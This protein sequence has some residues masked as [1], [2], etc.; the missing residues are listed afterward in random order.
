MKKRLYYLLLFLLLFFNLL[1]SQSQEETILKINAEQQLSRRIEETLKPFIGKSIAV[2]NLEL[3]YANILEKLDLGLGEKPKFKEGE[4]SRTRAALLSKKYDEEER[5]NT[6]VKKKEVILYVDKTLSDDKINFVRMNV[7]EWFN[8]GNDDVIQVRRTLTIPKEEEQEQISEKSESQAPVIINKTNKAYLF[9]GIVLIIIILVNILVFRS[10]IN[11]LA[12]SRSKVDVTGFDKLIRIYGGM[13]KG[14]AGG[15]TQKGALSGE[16][17]KPVP[18]RIVQETDKDKRDETL[19]FSFLEELSLDGFHQLINTE[20]K[21]NIGFVLSHLNKEFVQKYFEK[22]SEQTRGI[23]Q[24]MLKSH[25]KSKAET[26]KL[27]Y[28]LKEKFDDYLKKESL[29][30]EGDKRL[31]DI[32]NG[33]SAKKS[34]ALFNQIKNLDSAT[35]KKIKNK[36][37]LLEDLENLED[38]AIEQIIVESDHDLLVEFLAAIDDKI[39]SKFMGNMTYRAKSIIKEDLDLIDEMTNQEKSD[40]I[41]EM[42]IN[43]RKILNY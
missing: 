30:Y 14:G 36:V 19:D 6:I 8:F 27:R 40:I 11:K 2:V 21:E 3:E 43:I 1:N 33:L 24:V 4:V 17:K 23:I 31:V 37:L 10:S 42:L 41:D 28:R 35:F 12:N 20:K 5:V 15:G 32:I 25:T 18:I 39:K 9:L 34:K 22:Y 26:D 29:T 38:E 16:F 13:T 7:L